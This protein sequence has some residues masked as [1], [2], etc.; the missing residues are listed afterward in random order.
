[1]EREK[2]LSL[3]RGDLIE[4]DWFDI[5]IDETGDPAKARLLKRKQ[6]GLF[7]E[8][9]VDSASQIECLITAGGIDI[10]EDA[11]P[12]SGWQATPIA[13]VS[14]VKRIRKVKAPR[15]RKRLERIQ[16]VNAGGDGR[17]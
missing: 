8:L 15:G 9:R 11:V 6:Y 7:L 2:L 10:D 17:E 14:S 13:L 16:A 1:M 12:Q 5:L 3:Q 4:Y